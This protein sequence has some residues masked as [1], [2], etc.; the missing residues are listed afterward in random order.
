MIPGRAYRFLL[1]RHGTSKLTAYQGRLLVRADDVLVFENLEVGGGTIRVFADRIE[2][3]P[4]EMDELP[5]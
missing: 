2:G 3:E 1:R 4:V 5:D